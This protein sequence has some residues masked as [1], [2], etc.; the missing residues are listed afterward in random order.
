MIKHIKLLLFSFLFVIFWLSFVSADWYYQ[1][2]GL[3]QLY[4]HYDQNFN[5]WFLPKWS[6]ITNFLWSSKW[7]LAFKPS[8]LFRWSARNWLPYVYVYATWSNRKSYQWYFETYSS[9]DEITYDWNNYTW[10]NKN[11]TD[12]QIWN[13]YR[14]VFS[15]FFKNVGSGDY[16]YYEYYDFDSNSRYRHRFVVC[17]SSHTIWKSMCFRKQYSNQEAS[18]WSLTWYGMFY[19][20]WMSFS[21]MSTDDIGPAPWTNQYWVAQWENAPSDYVDQTVTDNDLINF[22]QRRY[23]FNSKMC[24]VNTTD[25]NSLYWETFETWSGSTSLFDMFIHVYW[26]LPASDWYNIIW[27]WIDFY[28]FNYNFWFNTD[29]PTFILTWSPLAN[30]WSKLYTWLQSPFIWQPAFIYFY[31]N[32]LTYEGSLVFGSEYYWSKLAQYCDLKLNWSMQYSWSDEI[33]QDIVDSKNLWINDWYDD[34]LNYQNPT[35][36]QSGFWD[37]NNYTWSVDI[38]DAFSQFY[39][40]FT[41]LLNWIDVDWNWII[42]RYILFFFAF[43]ILIR[44]LKK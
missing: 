26:R 16:V 35:S 23:N 31:M 27:R 43:A 38:Q 14:S 25:L 19:R 13:D 18:Y 44:L 15:N 11:C 3:N 37:K 12:L 4:S 29:N 24:Y 17:W 28:M 1:P 32:E 42:P 39:S 7:V 20:S 8:V 6:V 33:N 9:C 2:V 5:L 10:W 22:F 34:N 40:N 36:S 41:N 30:P 21:T